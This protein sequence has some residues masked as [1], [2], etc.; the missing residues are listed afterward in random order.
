MSEVSPEPAVRA[1]SESNPTE[2]KID[3]PA[4]MLAGLAD[5][6]PEPADPAA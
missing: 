5:L 2:R 6:F 3:H 1:V 4:S